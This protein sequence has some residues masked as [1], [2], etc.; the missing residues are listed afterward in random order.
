MAKT[1]IKQQIYTAITAF[2]T[3]ALPDNAITLFEVLG[4]HAVRR[5]RVPEKPFLPFGEYVNPEKARTAE[6]QSADLLFQLTIDDIHSTVNRSGIECIDDTITDSYIFFAIELMQPEYQRC[7][8]AHITREINKVFSLPVLVIFKYGSFITIAVI[9]QS[10]HKNDRNI[11]D[12]ISLIKDIAIKN[13]CR[14]HLETLF[15]LSLPE[16]HNKYTITDFAELRRAWEKTLGTRALNRRFYRELA[17][18]YLRA[19]QGVNFP[20]SDRPDSDYNAHCLIRILIQLL[21][22]WFIKEKGLIDPILF[23]KNYLAELL[24]DFDPDGTG[25]MTNGVRGCTYYRVVV[26]NLFQ[27]TVYREHD[28]LFI[29]DELWIPD[30]LFFSEIDADQEGIKQNQAVGIISIFKQYKFTVIENTPI[31]EE[32]ALDPEVLGRV[33]E[34]LLA[35]DNPETKITARK[36]TGTFYTP[37]EIADFMVT[38]SLKAYFTEK[39]SGSDGIAE[40]LDDLLAYTDTVHHFTDKEVSVLLNAIDQIKIL[41]PACGSGVFLMGMIQKL[42]FISGKLDPEHKCWKNMQIEKALLIDDADIRDK[43][44]THIENAF[45]HNEPDYI[46]KLYLMEKSMYGVDIQAAAIQ[47]SKLR[48]F[49][50]LIA[51]QKFNSIPHNP[52]VCLLPNLKTKL[53]V[54][55]ILIERLDP[56]VIFGIRGGF[57]VVIANPPYIGA[58]KLK[59]ISSQLKNNYTVYSGTA[60]ISSYFIEIG[61]K[62]CKH[63]GYMMYITT[64]KFFNTGYGKY[65]R[66]FLLKYQISTIIDFEQVRIFEHI[67][68]SSVILGMK[69]SFPSID[70]FCYQKFYRLNSEEFKQQFNVSNKSLRMYRQSLLNEDGWSFADRKYLALKEKIKI[71]GCCISELNGVSVH[72]G[73]TTGY[74]PAFI[75]DAEKYNELSVP[76]ST[77]KEIIKPLLQGRNIRKWYYNKNNTYIIFINGNTDIE[78]FP[79]VKKHLLNFKQQLLARSGK[80]NW[81]KI[82]SSTAYYAEFEKEKIIWGLTTA[83]WAFAYDDNRYYLPNNGYILTSDIIPVKYLLAVLNSRLMK[84]YFKF[85]GTMTAGGAYTLKYST[86]QQLPIK[87]AEDQAPFST[88]V[89]HIIDAKNKNKQTD[90]SFF[91]K[92]IDALVYQI[93]GLTPEEIIMVEED[94]VDCHLH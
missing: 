33:F 35:N 91:E 24:K 51:E 36:G 7:I 54:A 90:V 5:N 27:A 10:P 83:K 62:L 14:S 71:S 80:I 55:D 52:E 70:E 16:L 64:N 39:S 11:L 42:I 25:E 43:T 86:I 40:K 58:K 88:L 49:I 44:V 94:D 53:V 20:Y 92:K 3:G 79:A 57:D 8:L 93:Y 9:N 47:I 59:A 46:R 63:N 38:E 30:Y 72:R 67:L 34:N 60:D 56:E 73:I 4:Y 37:R 78:Q 66:S 31:E 13:P 32:H 81:Y 87:I 23:N 2:S 26:Q 85:I 18:W 61:M 75:I 48:F 74:N 15:Y 22:V 45:L 41:D 6:W 50:S 29:D 82:Q 17:Q 68:V 19:L 84:Y 28:R 12:K 65:I 69:K 76:D 21:F 1:N 77:G 89:N